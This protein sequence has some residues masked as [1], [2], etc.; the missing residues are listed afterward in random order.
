MMSNISSVQNKCRSFVKDTDLSR[1]ISASVSGKSR[2]TY[3]RTEGVYNGG[4]AYINKYSAPRKQQQQ[5]KIEQVQTDSINSWVQQKRKEEQTGMHLRF[6]R[7]TP[8]I[9]HQISYA[10][11]Q[12]KPQRLGYSKNRV[13]EKN[14]IRLA[15]AKQSADRPCLRLL[16]GTQNTL[17]GGIRKGSQASHKPNFVE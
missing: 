8:Y 3:F 6:F 14:R 9:T 2:V 12:T 13:M 11:H 4:E 17:T 5:I 7:S 10:W 1:C 15:V 16:T